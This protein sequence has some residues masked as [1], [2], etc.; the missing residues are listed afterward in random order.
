MSLRFA[1]IWWFLLVLFHSTSIK[2]A[3]FRRGD[4]EE[5]MT[6]NPGDDPFGEIG[7]DINGLEGEVT[8]R[9]LFPPAFMR[10]YTEF[11]SLNR[12]IE[13]SRW[14]VKSREDFEAIPDEPFDEYIVA[15]THFED[16]EQMLRTAGGKWAKQELDF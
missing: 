7:I 6:G 8:L 3:L 1:A 14:E 12:L 9:E 2:P 15:T 5:S 10:K 13:T 4:Y 11:E 16:W